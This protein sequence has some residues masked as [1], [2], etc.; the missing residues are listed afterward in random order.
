M[1]VITIVGL[2]YFFHAGGTIWQLILI[3][4]IARFFMAAHAIG[5]HRW[6]CHYSFTPSIF[7]K[8]LMLTGLVVTGYGKPLHLAVAHSMHHKYTDQP[9]DPHSPRD[10]SF[11]S[12][13]LGRYNIHDK[14]VVP[15]K[16]FRE[17]E[18][19]FVNQ[20]YWTLFFLFNALL[21]IIDL[22]TALVFC[23]LNFCY[24]W[25]LNTVINYYGHKNGELIEPT[26]LNNILSVFTVGESLHKTHHDN[27]SFYDFGSDNQKDLG[28]TFIEWF[29]ITR[30]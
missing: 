28:K 19:M 26:N 4:F 8:Y 29:L 13:L 15:T 25:T 14:Y 2:I 6:L 27:P 1:F 16:F 3:R 24:S 5:S 17:K 20:H 30:K 12:L 23:P 22:K 7:G 9:L 21:M 10:H 18:A 11:L